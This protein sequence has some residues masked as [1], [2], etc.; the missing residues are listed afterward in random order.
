MKIWDKYILKRFI[1]Y[2]VLFFWVLVFLFVLVDAVDNLD[3]FIDNRANPGDVVRYYLFYLPYIFA[4]VMPIVSVLS[5]GLAFGQ[6][7]KDREILSLEN[8]GVS[9]V[10][11]G[12]PVLIAG[13]IISLVVLVGANT[14]VPCSN[15]LKNE[16]K[17]E[18]IMKGRRN[19][20][21]SFDDIVYQGK[22]G[23][24][25]FLRHYEPWRNYGENASV[26]FF[27]DDKLVKR[28]DAEH[29]SFDGENLVLRDGF[30]RIF[31]EE[32]ETTMMFKI[33][34]IPLNLPAELLKKRT[35]TDEMG[36]FELMD[37]IRKMRDWGF[38]PL[39]E[40]VDLYIRF[41]FPFAS[42]ILLL[43]GIPFSLK[44]RRFGLFIGVGYTLLI[45]FVYYSAVRAGQALGYDGTFSPAFAALAPNII[46]LFAGIVFYFKN[47]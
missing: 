13:L 2:F 44:Y 6:A 19:P 16:V 43:F 24:I 3:K 11:A 32:N 45:S 42:F 9:K 25:V 14:F 4:F 38:V 31:T 34:S 40:Q 7:S 5:G 21:R 36:S 47:K 18:R 28:Y 33:K 8:G 39:K 17:T 35:T 15:R 30:M 1:L 29:F 37:F 46:F 41:S 22:R 12:A 27:K 20:Q 10:R 23:I 26:Q